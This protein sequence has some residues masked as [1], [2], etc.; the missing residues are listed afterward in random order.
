MVVAGRDSEVRLV[1]SM[2]RTVV[3]AAR[4]GKSKLSHC[5]ISYVDMDRSDEDVSGGTAASVIPNAW[6]RMN[7]STDVLV[8]LPVP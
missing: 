6:S 8:L 4:M 5:V 2:E 1:T 7:A 3:V